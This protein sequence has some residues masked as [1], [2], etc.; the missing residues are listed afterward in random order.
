[1]S[2]LFEQVAQPQGQSTYSVSPKEHRIA[3]LD[4]WRG[5]AILLV[6]A[7]HAGHEHYPDQAWANLGS[8]GV[9]I[10][11]VLSGYLITARLLEERDKSSTIDLKSF[12][13]RRA[14]RILPP[15]LCYLAAI[16]VLAF[17]LN[18]EIQPSQIIGAL[19]FF[20]NYQLAAHPGGFATGHFWSL[21]IEEHFYL[22]WPVLLLR[23]GNKRSLRVAIIGAYLCAI[24]RIYDRTFPHS[25][26]GRMLPGSSEAFRALRTDVMLDG[27]LLGSAL[28]ILLIRP[29]VR[30]FILRNFPKETPLVCTVILM[31]LNYPWAKGYGTLAHYSLLTVIVASTLIV[32]EGLAYK[33][34]NFAPLVWIGKLSYSLYIWQQIFLLHPVGSFPLGPMNTFPLNVIAL[35]AIAA[36]SFYLLEQPAIAMG[37]QVLHSIHQ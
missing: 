35:F 9:D 23:L 6:I 18:L 20:R 24:W 14:F 5:I 33:W 28:A 32:K 22:L 7:H 16:C 29:S 12:Y 21:S 2:T 31:M 34:L 15:V 26:I 11:F 13:I 37:R 30:N 25:L 27:L 10:F 3:T 4:G 36:C 17:F 8:L 1:M 19:F